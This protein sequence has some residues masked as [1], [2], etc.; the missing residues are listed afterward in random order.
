MIIIRKVLLVFVCIYSGAFSLSYSADADQGSKQKERCSVLYQEGVKVKIGKNGK[1]EIITIP[2][3]GVAGIPFPPS[4]LKVDTNAT[5]L[6]TRI[7]LCGIEDGLLLPEIESAV[8]MYMGLYNG[9]IEKTFFTHA[10]GVTWEF[11]KQGISFEADDATYVSEKAGA[12]IQ[13]TG[14]GVETKGIKQVLK[15]KKKTIRTIKKNSFNWDEFRRVWYNSPF[16]V[17]AA[18]N[19]SYENVR[20]GTILNSKAIAGLTFENS[21]GKNSFALLLKNIELTRLDGKKELQRL[22]VGAGLDSKES[23]ITFQV[24]NNGLELNDGAGILFQRST[25]EKDSYFEAKENLEDGQTLQTRTRDVWIYYARK[26]KKYQVPERR[27]FFDDS[28]DFY[29]SKLKRKYR[30][31]D[32]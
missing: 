9:Q 19:L 23:K 11:T 5:L 25:L 31:S 26:N 4:T 1:K 3:Y 22:Y 27:I 30:G 20:V 10:I 24:E 2:V 29:I 18:G 6:T 28:I 15:K 13:F 8:P 7:M 21:D 17:F 16:S 14:N 12:T 32:T